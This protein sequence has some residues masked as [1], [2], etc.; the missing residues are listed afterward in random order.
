VT[1]TAKNAQLS[2]GDLTVN[3]LGAKTP[4]EKG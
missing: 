4:A 1:F 3:S 2:D